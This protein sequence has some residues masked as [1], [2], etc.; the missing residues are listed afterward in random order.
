MY[1]RFKAGKL[2]VMAGVNHVFK[3]C[4]HGLIDNIEFLY[5]MLLDLRAK[6]A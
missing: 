2:G 6:G 4:R 1:L 5:P 3:Y